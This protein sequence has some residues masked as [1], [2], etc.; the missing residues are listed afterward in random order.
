M[1][2]INGDLLKTMFIAAAKAVDEH[3]EEINDLNVFPVPDGDTG[4]N[5]FMTLNSAAERLGQLAS[6]S[7]GDTLSAASESLLRG[8]RGNSGVITSLL[9]R[10]FAKSAKGLDELDASSLANALSEG[11]TTAY[12]AVMKPAEGTILTVSKVAAEAAGKACKKDKT[13]DGVLAAAIEAAR[14]ALQKTTEQ[15]PVLKKAGVV[16]AGGYGWIIILDAM[17]SSIEG[18]ASLGEWFRPAL[19]KPE[20]VADFTVFDTEE[21]NYAY[22]TEFIAARQNKRSPEK[23]RAFLESIG[24]CVVVVNDDKIIKVHVHTNTPDKALA[25]GLKHGTLSAIKIENMQE[26]HERLTAQQTAA[27]EAPASVPMENRY[28]FV[29]VAAGDGIAALFTELGA[30]EVVSG[31]QTMNP[32]TDDILKAIQRTPAE[33]VFVLPD[34]KNIIMAAEQASPL[35]DRQVI[36]LPTTTVPQG[37]SAMM[38]F[39]PDQDVESNVK[40]MTEAF[41]AVRTGSVTYAARDSEFDGTSIS[42]GDYLALSESKLVCSGA[43]FNDVTAALVQSLCDRDAAFITV[44]CGEGSDEEKTRFLS[45][46]LDQAAPSAEISFLDGDQPVYSYIISVE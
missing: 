32:S 12:K 16:D 34:N 23:T 33:V 21:I 22:C 13:V 43:S 9:F 24:D 45:V 36:V 7:L 31:G 8:A 27:S 38:S 35:S 44:L 5:M 46:A 1:N 15:N 3:K 42:A 11:V 25:E 40:A 28:G 10:G 30:D 2:T 17:Y 4:T 29:A 18:N 6:P 14:V 26:Q 41:S 39:N 19:T 20:S 37:L